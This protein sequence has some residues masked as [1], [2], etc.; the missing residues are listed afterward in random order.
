[1]SFASEVIVTERDRRRFHAVEKQENRDRFHQKF[2]SRA[3]VKTS[4]GAIARMSLENIGWRLEHQLKYKLKELTTVTDGMKIDSVIA[5]GALDQ[6]VTSRDFDMT[7]SVMDQMITEIW[8]LKAIIE[9]YGSFTEK[10]ELDALVEDRNAFKVWEI[11]ANEDERIGFLRL[12]ATEEGIRTFRACAAPTPTPTP[13]PT[14]IEKLRHR[15]TA[16]VG[17]APTPTSNEKLRPR[18]NAQLRLRS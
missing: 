9:K 10:L 17:A 6:L 7:Q 11:L 2:S 14:L 4:V 5:W 13:T 18:D 15:D 12:H 16:M 1:M 3:L 8:S